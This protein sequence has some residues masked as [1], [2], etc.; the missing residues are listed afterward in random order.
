M[1]EQ[2]ADLPAADADVACR[3]VRVRADVAVEFVHKG[4]AEAHN[5][6]IGLALG[7]KIRAA[8]AAAHREGGE[9]VLE[10]LL[11]GQ[12][13]QRAERDGRVEAQPALVRADGAVHLDP[14]AAVDLDLAV[15]VGPS[16]AEH[17]DA[18]GLG[19]AL[20]YLGLL[21]FGIL[22]DVRPDGLRN[23]R[24]GL[25]EFSF[26]GIALLE[27]GKKAR[28]FVRHKS[29]LPVVQEYKVDENTR[30]RG[31]HCQ[32]T[33]KR[34]QSELNSCSHTPEACRSTWHMLLNAEVLDWPSAT[35]C[36]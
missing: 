20:Q 12:E 8:L 6:L 13:L 1:A 31:N 3:H 34:L 26:R 27:R 21:V 4:L 32:P 28:Q 7:V 17:D 15:A 11:E 36:W 23:L 33:C 19:H 18:F 9:G 35:S 2:E 24:H 14:V 16:D 30:G 5:F 10:D 22:L 25:V 29:V